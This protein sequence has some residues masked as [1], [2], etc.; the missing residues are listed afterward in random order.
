MAEVDLLEI[1]EELY[2]LPLADFTPS[3]DA[4]AKRLSKDD[5][6]AAKRVKALRKPSTAAWVVNLLVR[7]DTE[8]VD[9]VLGIGD[10]LREAQAGMDAA[11]LR[12]L[13]K[14]RRQ[15]TAA[16][17]TR[18][19]ALARERGLR[20]TE[21]VAEQVEATLTA[22]MIDTGA[23]AAVRS[24]LLVTH[25]ETTGF[26]EF[27]VT[28]AVAVA[29][30]IGHQATPADKTLHVVP[31]SAEDDTE[32]LDEAALERARERL[33]GAEEALSEAAHAADA[34]RAD[35]DRLQARSL[36]VQAELEELR[37]RL[38][39]LEATAEE[40]DDELGEAEDA[41]V[42]AQAD[43]DEATQLRDQAR[44]ALQELTGETS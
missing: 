31:A 3:R 38:A 19:R 22:A 25:L 42:L 21:S 35:V 4:R 6:D 9:Q 27:D 20:V 11:Q 41:L 29:E 32:G 17:T 30:A 43:V 33:A 12:E 10:A 23:A 16:V 44:S 26:G 2:A 1:A 37:R 24:G 14:Q 39:E 18:A 34:H 36:Q 28:G 13:T 40:V 5:K 7:L 15:L 8:Q